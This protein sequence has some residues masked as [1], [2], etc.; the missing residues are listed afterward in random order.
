MPS[1]NEGR[2]SKL[3]GSAANFQELQAQ[4]LSNPVANSI[5]HAFSIVP[6]NLHACHVYKASCGF[7]D[8]KPREDIEAFLLTVFPLSEIDTSLFETMAE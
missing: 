7:F 2:M 8:V 4:W 5:S 1:L 3:Y 6:P